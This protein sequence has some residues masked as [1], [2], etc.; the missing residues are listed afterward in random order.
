MKFRFEIAIIILAVL[1]V[2]VIRDTQRTYNQ[3]LITKN[4]IAKKVSTI[5]I[6]VVEIK[7]IPQT[8][9]A[10]S[11]K[12]MMKKH[13]LELVEIANSKNNSATSISAEGLKNYRGLKNFLHELS[14]K[15]N[16]NIQKMCI[17]KKC[18]PEIQLTLKANKVVIKRDWQAKKFHGV[19]NKKESAI[20][21]HNNH[22]KKSKKSEK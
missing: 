16:I 2:F 3:W 6:P 8:E 17:G 11:I 15:Y 1:L 18:K 22:N 19:N 12:K 21:N 10:Q 7:P 5:H 13:G 14:Y 20:N 4:N 9:L